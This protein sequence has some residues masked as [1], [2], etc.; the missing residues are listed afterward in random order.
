MKNSVT[1]YSPSSWRKVRGIFVADKTF[2]ELQNKTVLQQQ[3]QLNSW[4]ETFLKMND[5]K[6][7]K[8][9]LSLEVLSPKLIK[10]DVVY[11]FLK[12]EIFTVVAKLPSELG[13]TCMKQNV[14]FFCLVVF[15]VPICFSC[16][17]ECCDTVLLWSSRNVLWAAELFP[18]FP[19]AW[20]CTDVD[21][22]FILV[23][24]EVILCSPLFLSLSLSFPAALT[25]IFL[26]EIIKLEHV[27]KLWT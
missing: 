10:E 7:K 23:H 4:M 1:V 3:Q 15:N 25:Y 8:I 21:Y 12:A 2:L 5:W 22:I 20:G 17:G 9:A 26:T 11:T 16:L 18:S 27:I 19:S 24:V 13:L 14:C 6:K